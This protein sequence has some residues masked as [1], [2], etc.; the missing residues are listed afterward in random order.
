[1]W[2]LFITICACDV[3]VCV[4]LNV[5]CSKEKEIQYAIWYC[6]NFLFLVVLLKVEC[7]N[8]QIRCAV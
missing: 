1:M 8:M 7:H 5:L 6:T 3:C 4:V 2:A